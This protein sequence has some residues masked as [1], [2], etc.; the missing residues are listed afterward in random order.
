MNKTR[1]VLPLAVL[2]ML[3]TM[4]SCGPDKYQASFNND[5]I[6]CKY[7]EQ[8]INV[9]LDKYVKNKIKF[10]SSLKKEWFVLPK[11][12]TDVGKSI[13]AAYP[14]NNGASALIVV[15]GNI[16]D[17]I[18]DKTAT[19]EMAVK[20]DAFTT[21]NLGGKITLTFMPNQLK[22]DNYAHDIYDK[23]NL[24]YE[25]D[26]TIESIGQ[27]FVS[28]IVD[29]ELNYSGGSFASG[30]INIEKVTTGSLMYI[31]DIGDSK[32]YIHLEANLTED[33]G[34]DASLNIT[35]DDNSTTLGEGECV[36]KTSGFTLQDS[37]KF[38]RN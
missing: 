20:E 32:Y 29:K 7:G 31:Y 9:T 18:G 2:L 30:R 5:Q 33:I 15:N 10:K 25:F 27:E 4:T 28:D 6:I 26:A 34:D 8:V 16:M 1:L 24:K 14:Y 13:L 12:Y 19:I 11:K 35:F 37:F 3:P 38:T 36:F 22:Y 23:D 17:S 21:P